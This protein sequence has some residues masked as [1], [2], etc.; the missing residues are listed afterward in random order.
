[1]ARVDYDK[2]SEVYDKGRSLPDEAVAVWMVGARRHVGTQARR[3]L[4]LGCGTGQWSNPLADALDARV[5]GLEPSSGMLR[6]AKQR[7][8]EP[9]TLAQGIAEHLP[10]GEA[11]FDAAW[12]SVVIHHF[13]DFA[14]VANQLRRVLKADAPVLIRG[15]FPG[16]GPIGSIDR[17]FPATSRVLD[18]YPSLEDTFATFEKAGF[19]SFYV[20]KIRQITAHNLRET[21]DRVKLRADTA[22][23][24]LTDEEFEQGLRA[25]EIA[26]RTEEGP[27]TDTLELAV[28]R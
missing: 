23:Q 20:E 18:T 27:V 11:T 12:L 7:A 17:F 4:D 22:L 26:A 1:M 15:A 10:F 28:I 6:H 8:G 13:D 21:L 2:Q 25:I 3:V 16:R 24:S 14:G 19:G 5:V 9:V